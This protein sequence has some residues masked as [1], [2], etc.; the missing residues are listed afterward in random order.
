MIKFIDHWQTL[1]AGIL[2]VIAGFGTIR[3]TIR[4]AR[5]QTRAIAE[6]TRQDIDATQRIA[7]DTIDAMRTTTKEQVEAITR[8]NDLLKAT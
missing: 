2:A 7:R 1:I 8:Q 4:S 5:I 3:A 6:A